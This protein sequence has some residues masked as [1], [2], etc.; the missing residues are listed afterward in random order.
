MVITGVAAH[1]GA[2][3]R[4]AKVVYLDAANPA[5]GQSLVDVAGPDQI[6]A[7]RPMGT[8][9]DGVELV[10][11]PSSDAGSLYGATDPDDL[12][13][14]AERLTGHP[15]KCFEQRLELHSTTQ[16]PISALPQFHIVCEVDLGV[17]RPRSDRQCVCGLPRGACGRSIPATL[18]TMTYRAAV[19]RRCP[20]GAGLPVKTRP[21]LRRA[22]AFGEL[23]AV[24]PAFA[25]ANLNE[26]PAAPKLVTGLQACWMWASGERCCAFPTTS[27]GAAGGLSGPHPMARKRP[28][29]SC[30]I[31]GVCWE[32]ASWDPQG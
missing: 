2:A 1:R 24:K 11:L 30:Q 27:L 7:V 6:E 25:E 21:G 32:P 9:V 16:R 23:R 12:A 8:V 29:T 4:I 14:M 19:C 28:L 13:W 31:Q 5:N 10:L 3:D 17:P 26:D 18:I 20:D 22:D 15:W